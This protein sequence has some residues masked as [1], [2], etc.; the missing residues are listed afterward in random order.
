MKKES[1]HFL[2]ISGRAPKMPAEEPEAM[3]DIQLTMVRQRFDTEK[4]D[5]VEQHVEK[6]LENIQA[7]P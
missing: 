7:R 6:K 3:L 1:V 4:I 5:N 2:R